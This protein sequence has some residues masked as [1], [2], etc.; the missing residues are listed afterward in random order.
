MSDRESL[1]ARIRHMRRS[2]EAGSPAEDRGPISEQDAIRALEARIVD[3]GI[4]VS[5]FDPRA[6]EEV[7]ILEDHLIMG[8]PVAP[9]NETRGDDGEI[10]A[11]V[12]RV[13][14][15]VIDPKRRGDR[16]ET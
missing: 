2:A 14:L 15:H 7:R 9:K 3:R 16:P 8:L 1:I 12:A 10:L 5:D 11:R 13:P 4:P 6:V